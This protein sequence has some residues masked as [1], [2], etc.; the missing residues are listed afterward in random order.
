MKQFFFDFS[1]QIYNS[2]WAHNKW[3]WCTC[4]S[5]TDLHTVR[6][7]SSLDSLSLQSVQSWSVVHSVHQLRSCVEVVCQVKWV[8]WGDTI[9]HLLRRFNFSGNLITTKSHKDNTINII[10]YCK[11][12]FTVFL[13]IHKKCMLVFLFAV[14]IQKMEL[15]FQPLNFLK[16]ND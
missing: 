3:G 1:I 10:V 12:I 9:K 7:Y 15:S 6:L 11:F 14:C 2:G 8:H 5:N 16:A 4:I 13:W